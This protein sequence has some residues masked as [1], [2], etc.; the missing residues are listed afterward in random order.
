LPQLQHVGQERI[1]D[2]EKLLVGGIDRQ[3]D[4]LRAAAHAAGELTHR[5]VSDC[6]ARAKEHEPTMSAPASSAASGTARVVRPQ[7][8]TRRASR[9]FRF[10][11]PF[12]VLE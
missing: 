10:V 12:Q 5:L 6:A 2:G 11:L 4:P 9:G 8:L 3:R 1:D 7:I